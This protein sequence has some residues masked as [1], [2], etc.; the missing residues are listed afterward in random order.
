MPDTDT[1]LEPH[2]VITRSTARVEARRMTSEFFMDTIVVNSQ[3]V[4]YPGTTLPLCRWRRATEDHVT[5]SGKY[6]SRNYAHLAPT[7]S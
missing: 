6:R 5:Q 3:V 2:P 7:M 4:K 1:A